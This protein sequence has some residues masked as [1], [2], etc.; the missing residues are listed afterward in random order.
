MSTRD[1]NAS[2][3]AA[4]EAQ[5]RDLVQ[6]LTKPEKVS[7]RTLQYRKTLSNFANLVRIRRHV[8]KTSVKTRFWSS[9][10]REKQ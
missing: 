10:K 8:T 5:V 7:F 1:I 2:L 6:D 4:N 3:K 9:A